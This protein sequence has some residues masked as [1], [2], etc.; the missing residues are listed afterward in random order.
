MHYT[1]YRVNPAISPQ[2]VEETESLR[3]KDPAFYDVVGIGSG[4][5]VPTSLLSP[6]LIPYP[7]TLN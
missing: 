6:S 1:N 4:E 7:R 5:G 3:D 2:K